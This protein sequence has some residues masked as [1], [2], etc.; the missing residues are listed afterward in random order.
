MD[1][2]Q[3]TLEGARF[4]LDGRHNPVLESPA[5][6]RDR[7]EAAEELRR[8]ELAAAAGGEEEDAEGEDQYAEEEGGGV[9]PVSGPAL[10]GGVERPASGVVVS[11]WWVDGAT[12]S[13]ARLSPAQLHAATAAELAAGCMPA[14][15]PG[16]LA[17]PPPSPLSLDVPELDGPVPPAAEEAGGGAALVGGLEALAAELARSCHVAFPALPAGGRLYGA[18][19]AALEA[20]GVPHVGSPAEAAALAADRV[21]WVAVGWSGWGGGKVGTD[22]ARGQLCAWS[23]SRAMSAGYGIW[24]G[25][26]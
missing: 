23:P 17:V 21:G 26:T 20:A 5:E 19:T 8:A 18:V 22:V 4:L 11:V 16:L 12:G 6:A 14:V 7:R 13:A 9:M 25:C 15:H 3:K 24:R 10:A 1:L 2:A